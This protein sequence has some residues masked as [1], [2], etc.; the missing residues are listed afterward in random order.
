MA[1]SMAVKGNGI[2]V[3]FLPFYFYT[4]FTIGMYYLKIKTNDEEQL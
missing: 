3:I 4:F 1:L 2:V